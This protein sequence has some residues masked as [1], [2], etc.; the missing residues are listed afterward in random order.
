[1]SKV[2]VQPS[3]SHEMEDNYFRVKGHCYVI[4]HVGMAAVNTEVADP[5]DLSRGVCVTA[6]ILNHKMADFLPLF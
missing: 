3:A 1:M 5:R 6:A 2:R 4:S